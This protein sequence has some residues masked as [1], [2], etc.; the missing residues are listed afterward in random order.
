M[1]YQRY[2]REELIGN[3]HRVLNSGVHSREFFRAMYRTL[4][5]GGAWRGE[6]CNKAKNGSLYWVDTTV[7]PE[8]DQDGK[9]SRYM[10]IRIDITARKAAE[11][12]LRES[13]D[14]VLRKS[15]QLELALA[16]ISQ[17]LC[18]FDAEQRVVVCNEQYASMYGLS[19]DD[20]KPG[21]TLQ[22]ILER[23]VENGVYA[24]DTAED[25]RWNLLASVTKPTHEVLNLKD[26]RAIAISREP[27]PGG[28]WVTTHQDITERQRVEAQIIYIASHDVLTGLA[29][30][31]V[32][33][34][35]MEKYLARLRRGGHPFAVFMLDLDRF[36]LVN[37]SLGH[38]IGDQF[39]DEEWDTAN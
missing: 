4:A 12:A 6:V 10:A 33:H 2:S 19:R 18:M 22:E 5:R 26:G 37:D 31:A 8:L 24:R 20:T 23:R 28:G 34:E 17:G 13:Q 11:K 21:T 3:N 32:L 39:E 27:I 14:E 25:Y 7:V 36:K 9:P 16:N 38:P 35:N 30:R 15:S 1:P 29:N